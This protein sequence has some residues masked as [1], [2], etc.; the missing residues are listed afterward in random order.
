MRKTAWVVGAVTT[1]LLVFS[2]AEAKLYRWVDEDGQIHFSDKMPPELK[3]KAHATIDENQGTVL[4]EVEAARSREELIRE[5]KREE[6]LDRLRAQQQQLVEE[7][8]A[9]DQVLLRTFHSEDDIRLVRNNKIEALNVKSEI[10]R[11]NIRRVKRELAELQRTAADTE[12]QGRKV[13]EA[14]LKE[15][16]STKER[17][18]VQYAALVRHEQQKRAIEEDYQVTVQRF[19]TLKN[20]EQKPQE[21][22]IA[23]VDVGL[24]D[25]SLV[26]CGDE[27]ACAAMWERAEAYVRKNATTRV[28]SVGDRVIMTAPP[29]KDE[30]VSIT[31]S[32]VED[33]GQEAMIFMDLQCGT[34]NPI[35]RE[36]C[37]SRA[38]EQIRKGF[39]PFI[40]GE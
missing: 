2:V 14:I 28:Q 33:P 37:E 9:K 19:R 8:E 4:E 1:A 18:N 6:E 15:M 25:D 10:T 23:G 17:L 34:D 3:D 29:R 11:G 20:L 13:S 31:V 26:P 21:E 24:L 27:T 36:F 12:R 22:E 5:A 40:K 30:E 35:S 38:V 39:A 7:Q 32:R 16:D